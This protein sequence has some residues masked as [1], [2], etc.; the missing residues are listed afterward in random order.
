MKNQRKILNDIV[1]TGS[2]DNLEISVSVEP[3]IF[4]R[5]GDQT[6]ILSARS[7]R[8]QHTNDGYLMERIRQ[9][10]TVNRCADGFGFTAVDRRTLQKEH[11]RVTVAFDGFNTTEAHGQ[12]VPGQLISHANSLCGVDDASATAE[13]IVGLDT[14][15]SNRYLFNI[16]GSQ[17]SDERQGFDRK[18]ETMICSLWL[19][20]ETGEW[21]AQR[22]ET[23][24]AELG[25]LAEAGYD[26]VTV[27]DVLDAIVANAP[28]VSVEF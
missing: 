8:E 13:A 12:I 25:P 22:K 7:G 11:G 6:R 4:V 28:R 24:M 9:A 2:V 5:I 23:A 20:S 10:L 17:P 19:N 1:S 18:I 26:G 27:H 3:R 16:D 14:G 21:V 15:P